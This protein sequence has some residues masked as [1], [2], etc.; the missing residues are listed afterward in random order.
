MD[1]IT[2]ANV[3]K[4]Y[5]GRPGCMCGCN[6]KWTYSTTAEADCGYEPAR[7]DR[8]VK[9]MFNKVMND[10]ARIVDEDAGC[11]YVETESRMRAIYFK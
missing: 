10:P 2:L 9:I 6:G 4:V 7:S 11:V 8:S 5:S 3:K 1:N